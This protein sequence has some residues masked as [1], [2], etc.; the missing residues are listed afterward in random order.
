MKLRL[1]PQIRCSIDTRQKQRLRNT[2]VR[3]KQVMAN[4]IKCKVLDFNDIDLPIGAL[5]GRTIRKL[6]IDLEGK[7][8]DKVLI[9]IKYS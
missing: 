5:D 3:H 7:E 6:I 1:M 4:L 8:G 2:I 9:V